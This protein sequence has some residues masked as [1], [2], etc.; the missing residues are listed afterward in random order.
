M[1]SR[2]LIPRPYEPLMRMATLI[3]V[4]SAFALAQAAQAAEH[5][6]PPVQPA[7]DFPAVEVHA[8]EHL[9]IAAEPYN[10]AAQIKLFRVNYFAHGILPVRL[11]V[12]NN[13]DRTISL[14]E[15]RILFITA[16]GDRIQAA[17]PEDVQRRL[18]NPGGSG[19]HIPM[20]SPI[21]GLHLKHKNINKK[22]QADFDTFEFSALTVAPHTTQAGFLFYD[23]D[24]LGDPLRGAAL[25]LH[26]LRDADGKEL[27][28]FEIPFDKYL[29]SRSSQMN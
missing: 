13:G 17:E 14:K 29:T 3:V 15:A 20:P 9:A 19:S 11:I 25:N 28:Y 4:A 1:S 8:N 12:T 5:K 6:Q 16:A 23:I 10:T 21:P 7:T 26:T 24:G 2:T 18:S 27:F 22:I